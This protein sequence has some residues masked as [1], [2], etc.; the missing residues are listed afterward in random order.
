MLGREFSEEHREK[1]SASAKG[2][3]NALGAVRSPET[4]EKMGASKRGVKMTPEQLAL[5]RASTTPEER[6]EIIRRAWETRRAK[7]AQQQDQTKP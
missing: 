1:L 2:K 3:R 4:R 5:K 6:S 7:A